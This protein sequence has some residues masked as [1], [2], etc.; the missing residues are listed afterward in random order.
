MIGGGHGD[1]GASSHC[2]WRSCNVAMVPHG[3]DVA[4]L[5]AGMCGLAWT[6]VVGLGAGNSG[7]EF[8]GV[9]MMVGGGRGWGFGSRLDLFIFVW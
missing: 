8:A 4:D 1:A 3:D 9:W 5:Q 2:V 7:L 6:Y